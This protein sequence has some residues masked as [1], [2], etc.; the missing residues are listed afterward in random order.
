MES[1]DLKALLKRV[2]EIV[3]PDLRRYYRVVRKA[4]VVATYASNGQYFCD[5]QPL[6]N[7][8]S[9]DEREPVI[10]GVEIP[11]I[12]AGQ[13]RGVVCPPAVGSMCDL[14]YYDGDPSYPRI[15][16]FR[17]RGNGAPNASV[18]EFIIQHAPGVHIR[19]TADGDIDMVTGTKVTITS[20]ETIVT[21]TQRHI[22]DVSIEGNLTVSGMTTT[23]GFESKG[24][25]GGAGAKIKGNVVVEDGDVEADN[26]SVKDHRHPVSDGAEYTGGAVE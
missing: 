21:T 6:L 15:S 3:M 12:W 20:P 18:N 9:D 22:G 13:L 23:G 5:V 19:I 2:V 14:E 16:N 1:I 17:W 11:V 10:T 25:V 26:I 4:R 8:E 24:T 7:D